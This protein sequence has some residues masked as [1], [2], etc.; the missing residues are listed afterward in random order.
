MA[1]KALEAYLEHRQSIALS[2]THIHMP[3]LDGTGLARRI[4][5]IGAAAKVMFVT[6]FSDAV[7]DDCACFCLPKPFTAAQLLEAIERC[8]ADATTPERR[9]S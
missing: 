6:G 7:P 1:P 5:A 9:H 2:V 3:E 8:L 4:R